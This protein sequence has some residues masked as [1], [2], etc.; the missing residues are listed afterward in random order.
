MA[1]MA[2]AATMSVNH[3]RREITEGS[4]SLADDENL[5]LD[6]EL[7]L[8]LWDRGDVVIVTHAL[9]DCSKRMESIDRTTWNCRTIF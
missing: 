6:D 5:A 2:A 3:W 8:P 9:D 4:H 7:Y 1:P